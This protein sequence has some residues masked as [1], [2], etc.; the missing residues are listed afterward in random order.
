LCPCSCLFLC[1]C[2]LPLPFFLCV[3]SFIFLPLRLFLC[4]CSCLCFLVVFSSYSFPKRAK[5]CPRAN[6]R[7]APR[8]LPSVQ[9]LGS[10]PEHPAYFHSHTLE[11]VLPEASTSYSN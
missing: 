5:A 6:Q 7:H 3:C 8:P 11:V 2:F 10:S 9:T 4:P 1:S